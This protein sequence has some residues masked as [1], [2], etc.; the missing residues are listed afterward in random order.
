M[1]VT[2]QRDRSAINVGPREGY[3]FDQEEIHST[4]AFYLARRLLSK[5]VASLPEAVPSRGHDLYITCTRSHPLVHG[6]GWRVLMKE[7]ARQ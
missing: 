5:R 3:V 7:P 2:S 1:A 4:P 6:C